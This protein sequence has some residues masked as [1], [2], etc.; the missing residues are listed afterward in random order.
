MEVIGCVPTRISRCRTSGPSGSELRSNCPTLVV[1]AKPPLRY[2]DSRRLVGGSG[3]VGP[4]GALRNLP[5]GP[6]PC[7]TDLISSEI[8]ARSEQAD[9]DPRCPNLLGDRRV[10]HEKATRGGDSSLRERLK[11]GPCAQLA[12]DQRVVPN[13]AGLLP[14]VRRCPAPPG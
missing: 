6:K 13:L 4:S 12:V 5:A 2:R 10:V 1:P 7:A 11:A 9:L 8:N 3:R 14:A